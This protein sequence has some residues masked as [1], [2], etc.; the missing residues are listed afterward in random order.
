[1]DKRERKKQ[2]CKE[3]YAKNRDAH[4]RRVVERRRERRRRERLELIAGHLG[5]AW[6][7]KR[8]TWQLRPGEAELL[9]LFGFDAD[10]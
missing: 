5:E 8:V 4:I 3:W 9:R 1:M 2:I 10:R 6:L 7:E